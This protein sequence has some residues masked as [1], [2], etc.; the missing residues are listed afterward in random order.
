MI[1]GA[2]PP[3]SMLELP[4]IFEHLLVSFAGS[5]SMVPSVFAFM[6]FTVLFNYL[7]VT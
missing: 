5:L 6:R 7:T 1:F 4:K 2:P 3:V